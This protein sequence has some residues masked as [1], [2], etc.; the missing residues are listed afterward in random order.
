LIL[1]YN[2]ANTRWELLNPYFDGIA[3]GS[4]GFNQVNKTIISGQTSATIASGDSVLFGDVSDTDNLKKGTVADI[5]SLVPSATVIRNHI[6]GYIMS[7]AGASATMT[8]SDGQ[9]SDS[10]N[11]VYISLAS[12]IN[13]TTSAW[14][15]G[16]GNGG[17][18]TGSIANTTWYHF[19]AI[20]RPDTGVVDVIFSTSASVPTLPANYTQYR[21][22]GAGKTNGSAQW[23]KFVQNG[24]VFNLDATVLDIN[25][26]ATGTS[27][28]TGTLASVPT[29]VIVT[30]LLQAVIVSNG[31]YVHFSPLSVSDEAPSTSAAPLAFLGY[32][33]GGKYFW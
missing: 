26:G 27:A 9:A 8:I 12:S 21:R 17:I 4:V 15:V 32:G 2:L 16:S 18:D 29:G 22:I 23:V 6:D 33:Y 31:V 11:A 25:D 7:T 30:A 19:Y 1:K 10:T 13:K 14:A 3:N 20:R 5:L 28:K 24:D